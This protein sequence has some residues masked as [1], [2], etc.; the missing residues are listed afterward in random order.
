MAVQVW[1]GCRTA[2][3]YG[4]RRGGQ[5]LYVG[6]V[7]PASSMPA[8]SVWRSTAGA[9]G[10]LDACGFGEVAQAA[11]SQGRSIWAPRVFSRIAR[12]SEAYRPVYGPATAGGS[13]TKTNL[14]PL[15]RHLQHPVAVLLAEVG[16]VRAGASKIRTPSSPSMA[17]SAKS[18]GWQTPGR[19]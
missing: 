16:D 15:P 19:R 10:D 1:A 12:G 6:Q 3:L 18:K 9:P 4:G 2:S 5:D 17:T 11:G 13:G 8:T 14:M 7:A